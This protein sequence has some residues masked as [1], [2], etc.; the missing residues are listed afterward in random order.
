MM[1]LDIADQGLTRP[2]SPERER[3]TAPSGEP[4]A[5]ALENLCRHNCKVSE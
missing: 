4:R 1:I 3:V 5:N 2:P